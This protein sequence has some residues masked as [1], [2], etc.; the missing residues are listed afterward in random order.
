M[1]KKCTICHI[2]KEENED[3]FYKKDR[4]K[5]GFDNRCKECFLILARYHNAKNYNKKIWRKKAEKRKKEGKQKKNSKEMMN[6]YPL[7][8]KARYKLRNKVYSGK[9][10]KEAC[11]VCGNK[12]VQA[13]HE[14]YN[15]PFDVNWLC[16]E[17]HRDRH[18]KQKLSLLELRASLLNKE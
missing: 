13:H 6:K 17:H 8:Y 1:Y 4:N 7:K 14:D 16:I 3:N 11:E 10:K 9:I 15:K 2:E 5:S 12:K 18:R